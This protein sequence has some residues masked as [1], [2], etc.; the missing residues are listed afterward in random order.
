MH[1]FWQDMKNLYH[2]VINSTSFHRCLSLPLA[3]LAVYTRGCPL[4]AQRAGAFPVALSLRQGAGV[5]LRIRGEER[6]GE[7]R[8]QAGCV[9]KF[10]NERREDFDAHYYS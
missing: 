8:V 2:D 3:H 9:L 6:R 5:A 10:M 7:D 4:Q 1:K